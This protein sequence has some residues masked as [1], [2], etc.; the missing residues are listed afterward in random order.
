L[1]VT[2]FNIIILLGSLQGFILALVFFTSVKLNRRSNFFLALV[3]LSVSLVNLANSLQDMGVIARNNILWFLPFNCTLLIPF[4][5]CYFIFYLADTNLKISKKEYLLLVP[6]G[7]QLSL[8]CLQLIL[9]FTNRSFLYRHLSKFD[10]IE[11]ALEGIAI[12]YCIIVIIVLIKRIRIFQEQ[13]QNNY[14]DIERKSL[15]WVKQVLLYVTVLWILWII[16]YL[17]ASITHTP[18]IDYLYPLWLGIAVAVYWLAYTMHLRRDIF[19]YTPALALAITEPT[20][21]L[22]EMPSA[23]EEHYKML[24]RLMEE[25]KLYLDMDISMTILAEKMQLSKG[26]LSKIINQKEGLNFYDYINKYRVAEVIKKL[27][28]P[29][30]AHLSMYGLALECGFKSKSTFNLSFKKTTGKTPSEYKSTL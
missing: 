21:P 29:A 9:Y 25:E 19:E 24:T 15:H 4:C 5:L 17:Y 30:F 1:K 27:S 13:L 16:P 23:W 20:K 2:I 18:L 8:K 7:I 3:L 6:F 26:Y 11:K 10:A 22:S 12:V 14:A 28:D